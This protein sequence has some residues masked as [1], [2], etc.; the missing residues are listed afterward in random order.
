MT[1][2][3][4]VTICIIDMDDTDETITVIATVTWVS[5]AKWYCHSINTYV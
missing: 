4:H 5:Y 2:H 1:R 3:I